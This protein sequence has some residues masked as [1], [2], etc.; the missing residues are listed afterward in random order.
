MHLALL[1]TV[2]TKP[3]MMRSLLPPF[4]QQRNVTDAEPLGGAL[5]PG[6]MAFID[7]LDP[8][9]RFARSHSFARTSADACA[10]LNLAQ[11]QVGRA[12]SGHAAMLPRCLVVTPLRAA[13]SRVFSGK[14]AWK[15]DY[16]GPVLH[17]ISAF[18]SSQPIHLGSCVASCF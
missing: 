17:L 10:N 1:A 12:A 3:E 6:I 11:V 15:L 5:S 9:L 7:L 8:L 2:P 13:F 14:F 18:V 4:D 16:D